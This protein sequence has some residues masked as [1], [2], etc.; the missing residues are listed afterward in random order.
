MVASGNSIKTMKFVKILVNTTLISVHFNS[1]RLT[2]IKTG[3][4]YEPPVF[5][6]ELWSGREDLNAPKAHKPPQRRA[7]PAGFVAGSAEEC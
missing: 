4:S 7:L 5:I 2:K 6:L 1:S 3:S